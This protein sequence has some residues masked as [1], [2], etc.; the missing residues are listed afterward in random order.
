M[1]DDCGSIPQLG[2]G[3]FSKRLHQRVGN[4]RIPLSGSLEV[5]LRCNLRCQH[6]YIPPHTRSNRQNKELSYTEIIRILDEVVD[7]GC[8]WL[9][10]T[11]GE[12]MLRK[13]FLD[14]Y[15]YARRKGLILTLFTNGTLLTSRIADTLAELRPFNIEITLYGA[16]QETYERVTGIPGS[17]SRCRQG[18]DMLLERKLPL[19]LK[20]LVLTLNY[21]ELEEMKTLAHALG[22]NFRF[23]TVVHSALDGSDRPIAL[24][25]TPQ[26]VVALDKADLEHANIWQALFK[27]NKLVPNADRRM[28]L[29]GAGKQG[30]H[31]DAAGHLCICMNTRQHAFDLKVGSFQEGWEQF[32]IR[33]TDREYSTSFPCLS[34]EL[35]L[36]C[37]QC[38]AQAILENGE[39]EN[40]V[41]FLCQITK[42]RRDV[43]A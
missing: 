27:K 29:C 11:G 24:R 4:Q 30:F 40:P 41:D 10:L 1:I 20:T 22:V 39:V 31:I 16:T 6:C 21:Y 12:P 7:A 37:A 25:L 35:R 9:L 8:L 13:D 42:L 18:I 3:E 14:I 26:Q 32:L 15:T 23:D 43:F 36:V 34:C 38:P 17:Y 28:Y 2:Y 33:V 19:G 5:T